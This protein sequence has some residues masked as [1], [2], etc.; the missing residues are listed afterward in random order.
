MGVLENNGEDRGSI[1]G[2]P[3]TRLASMLPWTQSLSPFLEANPLPPSAPHVSWSVCSLIFQFSQ[4][5]LRLEV[6]TSAILQ[7]VSIPWGAMVPAGGELCGRRGT[8]QGQ[9]R[10]SHGLSL[11]GREETGRFGESECV[12][13]CILA[14]Q[15]GPQL[16]AV[17]CWL[18]GRHDPWEGEASVGH[19][20]EQG[21][22]C[23]LGGGGKG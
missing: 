22:E 14:S 11:N 9:G 5:W 12:K 6:A 17:G 15:P 1:C 21:R 20:A 10:W 7:G 23:V 13:W 3:S 16:G 4:P 19:W 8:S 2:T 18:K